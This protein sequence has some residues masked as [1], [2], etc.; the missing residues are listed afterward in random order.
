MRFSIEHE[1][2]SD[3]PHMY[4]LDMHKPIPNTVLIKLPCLQ[5][6]LLSADYHYKQVRSRPGPNEPS[7]LIWIQTI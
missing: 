3:K 6:R 5:L 1:I 7:V 2:N 4:T